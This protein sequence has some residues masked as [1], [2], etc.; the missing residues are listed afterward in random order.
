MTIR[1]C[2]AQIR[3]CHIPL[4][5]IFFTNHYFG[6]FRQVFDT[7]QDGK[8]TVDGIKSPPVDFTSKTSI[9]QEGKPPV[10]KSPLHVCETP[11]H[12]I[13]WCT[14]STLPMFLTSSRNHGPVTKSPM[15]YHHL[16]CILQ[17]VVGM[18]FHCSMKYHRDLS[19]KYPHDIPSFDQLHLHIYDTKWFQAG[20]M[21]LKPC[22]ILKI[23]NENEKSHIHLVKFTRVN[24]FNQSCNMIV[25]HI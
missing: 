16:W 24:H 25:N 20:D 9:S 5:E 4:W 23:S 10:F 19:M 14:N 7:A 11:L 21:L 22:Q 12:G 3:Y 2:T 1:C 6:G 18:I 17:Y 13:V 8:K 15:T